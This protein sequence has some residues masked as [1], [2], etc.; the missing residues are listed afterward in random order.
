MNTAVIIT[1]IICLTLVAIS[2]IGNT[3]N[4]KK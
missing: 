3:K 2:L 4:N 1:I